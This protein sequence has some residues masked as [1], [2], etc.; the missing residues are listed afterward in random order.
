MCKC[1]MGDSPPRKY[2]RICCQKLGWWTNRYVVLNSGKRRFGG[3]CLSLLR[4]FDAGVGAEAVS[5]RVGSS[6]GDVFVGV[7]AL[8]DDGESV[9]VSL[10]LMAVAVFGRPLNERNDFFAND[11]GFGSSFGG[12][13]GS[14]GAP[15]SAGD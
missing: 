2:W 9:G 10:G 1:G 12:C 6:T 5:G 14:F 3:S 7:A 8:L 15:D 11:S 4:A 13:S